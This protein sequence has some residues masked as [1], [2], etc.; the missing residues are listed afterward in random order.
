M[1]DTPLWRARLSDE[2]KRAFF[3]STAKSLPV[4]KSGTAEDVAHA[5]QFLMENSFTTGA[6]LDIDGGQR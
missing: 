1:I 5:V 4:G 6:V 3:A 2:E